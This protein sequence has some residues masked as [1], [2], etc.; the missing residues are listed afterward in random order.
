MSEK[1]SAPIIN[2]PKKK[3]GKIKGRGCTDTRKQSG[4]I[5]KGDNIVLIMTSE[6][7]FLTCLINTM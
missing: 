6:K 7:L 5:T 4:Y 3:C 2:V 1:G